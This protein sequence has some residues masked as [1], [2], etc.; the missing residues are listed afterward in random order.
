MDGATRREADVTQEEAAAILGVQVY[1]FN[2]DNGPVELLGLE[3]LVEYTRKRCNLPAD[4]M[5]PSLVALAEFVRLGAFP[6]PDDEVLKTAV[7]GIIT[8]TT[9]ACRAVSDIADEVQGGFG[10]RPL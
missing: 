10:E 3:A 5:R 4:D 1:R 8:W 6:M 7:E 9:L 2:D